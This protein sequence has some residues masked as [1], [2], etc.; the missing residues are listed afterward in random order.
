MW[1]VSEAIL[2]ILTS[3]HHYKLSAVDESKIHSPPSIREH[4]LSERP[5]DELVIYLL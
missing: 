4:S 3:V 2:K 1:Q 5:Q